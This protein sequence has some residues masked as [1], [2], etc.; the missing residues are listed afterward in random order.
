MWGSYYSVKC[1]YYLYISPW[2]YAWKFRNRS[3]QGCRNPAGV[4]SVARI[5]FKAGNT[6]GYQKVDT[7]SSRF[8]Y[9][10]SKRSDRHCSSEIVFCSWTVLHIILGTM[11]SRRD[12]NCDERFYQP[13]LYSERFLHGVTH[14]TRVAWCKLEWVHSTPDH[15][16]Q[17]ETGNEKTGN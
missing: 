6:A 10:R 1:Q 17:F 14:V 4:A 8:I 11:K 16:I 9:Y 3:F 2:E 12:Q 15:A 7:I 13:Y 5:L